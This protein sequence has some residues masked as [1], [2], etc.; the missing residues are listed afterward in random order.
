[1][2]NDTHYGNQIISDFFLSITSMFTFQTYRTPLIFITDALK[3]DVHDE[4]A[5]Q[6]TGHLYIASCSKTAESS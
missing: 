1:M 4:V 6:T 2:C 5:A 3:V